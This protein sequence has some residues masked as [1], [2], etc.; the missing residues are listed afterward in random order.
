MAVVKYCH[1]KINVPFDQDNIDH[2][3]GVGNKYTDEN[4]GEKIQSIIVKFK[5][6]KS[7]KS[8]RMLDQEILSMVSRN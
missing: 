8:F 4:T 2:I 1:E 5:S 7:V 3:H 6:W